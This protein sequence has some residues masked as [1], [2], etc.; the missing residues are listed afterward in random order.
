MILSEIKKFLS[1]KIS[2]DRMD[3]F[4]RRY[5]CGEKTLDV[6]CGSSYYSEYFP[7][8]IGFDITFRDGVNIIGDAISLPFGDE[9][10]EFVLCTEVIEHLKEPQRAIGEM[11]RVLKPKGRLLLTTRF[12]FPLHDTPYDYYRFTKYGLR[13]LLRDWKI[14]VIEEEES[15]IG[16]LGILIQRIGIAC[17][18]LWLKIFKLPFLIIGKLLSHFSFILVE[19]Y[20]NLRSRTLEKN[21]LTSAYYVVAEKANNKVTVAC[22]SV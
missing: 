3:L 5:A 18:I 6:G 21:I 10:F 13:Y 4:I 17:N 14:L 16:R 12:V 9:S 20:G 11:W 15:T 2:R 22:S 1:S 7:D 19:E 8:R